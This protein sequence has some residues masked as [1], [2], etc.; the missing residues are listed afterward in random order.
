MNTSENT[1]TNNTQNTENTR[2]SNNYNYTDDSIEYNKNKVPQHIKDNMWLFG[3]G[4][5]N[6]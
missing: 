2:N 1:P 4:R 3:G 5:K 6:G